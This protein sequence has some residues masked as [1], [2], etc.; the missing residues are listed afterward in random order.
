MQ[1]LWQ[2]FL[3]DAGTRWNI[4]KDINRFYMESPAKSLEPKSRRRRIEKEEK[5]IKR[6]LT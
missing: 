4:Y 1:T 6:D 2:A 3:H 5:E